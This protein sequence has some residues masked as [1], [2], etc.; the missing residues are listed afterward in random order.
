MNRENPRR[1]SV[2]ACASCDAVGWYQQELR[3]KNAHAPLANSAGRQPRGR[4]SRAATAVLL[5]GGGTLRLSSEQ[6]IG[7]P[8]P[9]RRS[10][11]DGTVE[12]RSLRLGGLVLRAHRAAAVADNARPGAVVSA[13]HYLYCIEH[14]QDCHPLF[15]SARSAGRLLFR[16]L[17]DGRA[18][19]GAAVS[20]AV[21]AS[22]ACLP[23]DGGMGP[24]RME[25]L[26][27][28]GMRERDSGASANGETSF[29]RLC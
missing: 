10:A 16:L 12:F 1:R 20:G 18:G 7:P 6:S 29:R 4:R 21:G 9:P 28:A 17:V 14:R 24:R 3:C 2:A 15:H 11:R 26:C 23:A 22:A 19:R 13:I 8:R 5:A 27:W 25:D